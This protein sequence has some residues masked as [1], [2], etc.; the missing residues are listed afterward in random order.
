MPAV[1][2]P[3][4]RFHFLTPLYDS[5]VKVFIPENKIKEDLIQLASAVQHQHILDFGCG[6][7][8]LAIHS[9]KYFPQTE[10]YG[11][12]V[13]EKILDYA[14]GKGERQGVKINFVQND[15]NI[16]PFSNEKFDIVFST[17]VFHHLKNEEKINALNE[18][19]RTLKHGGYF[20]LSDF[21]KQPNI[22]Q[23]ILFFNLRLFDGFEIT[24]GNRKGLLPQFITESGFHEVK[25][26]KSYN[27]AFGIIE[28][29]AAIKK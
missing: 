23:E 6:T 28:T 9:K 24:S 26:L 10:V 11:I 20:F 15:G 22:F 1:F 3:A 17:L 7:G 4:L 2:I 21:G 13:D 18:I 19:L 12:D 25:I 16:L 29:V 8:T 27:S 14:I 5:L